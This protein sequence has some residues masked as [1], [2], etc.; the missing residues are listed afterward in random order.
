MAVITIKVSTEL[1]QAYEK[2]TAIQRE[3]I[4]KKISQ[5]LESSLTQTNQDIEELK[6][7]MDDISEE[8]VQNGLTPEILASILQN[9]I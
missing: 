5:I 4:E 9:E 3:D 7:I 2:I 8:A 1:A 6:E